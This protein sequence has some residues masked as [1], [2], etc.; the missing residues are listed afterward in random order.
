MTEKRK[1]LLT[2]VALPIAVGITLN[3]L[4]FLLLVDSFRQ[5]FFATGLENSTNTVISIIST[6]GSLVVGIAL[7]MYYLRNRHV[8]LRIVGAIIIAIVFS[9][10]MAL[11]I[12]IYNTVTMMPLGPV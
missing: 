4:P 12:G 3:L 11:V 9:R 5:R 1:K 8:L 10:L 7:S 2:H 6:V